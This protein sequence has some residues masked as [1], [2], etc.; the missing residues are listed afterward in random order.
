MQVFKT[1]NKFNNFRKIGNQ[2]TN[3]I[4][5]FCNQIVGLKPETALAHNK[6]VTI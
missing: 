5:E 2:K 3:F 1:G 6:K 4:T